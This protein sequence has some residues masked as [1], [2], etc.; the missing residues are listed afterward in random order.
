MHV[1][2]KK[3][4]TSMV[5]YARKSV[6]TGGSLAIYAMTATQTMT[7]VAARNAKLKGIT[8]AKVVQI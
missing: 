4:F 5:L 3:A 2:A 1:N 7:M 6:V 8:S